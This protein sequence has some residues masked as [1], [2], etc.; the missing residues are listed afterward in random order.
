MSGLLN[1]CSHRTVEPLEKKPLEYMEIEADKVPQ[2]MSMIHIACERDRYTAR[3]SKTNIED[4]RGVFVWS[5]RMTY[6]PIP[7]V[8][9]MKLPPEN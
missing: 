4:E 6:F 9:P 7:T 5:M 8:E 3:Y 1:E 2:V